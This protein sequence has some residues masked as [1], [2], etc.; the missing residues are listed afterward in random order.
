MGGA[1]VVCFGEAKSESG[2]LLCGFCFCRKGKSS[3]KEVT[4]YLGRLD[5]L[6]NC[7]R[8]GLGERK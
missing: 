1:S 3:E 4:S 6:L 8:R 7:M 5:Y 2:E